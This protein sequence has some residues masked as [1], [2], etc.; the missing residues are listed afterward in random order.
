[1][2][3]WSPSDVPTPLDYFRC[4]VA[5]DTQF[6]LLEAAASLA[7]DPYPQADIESVLAQM[8]AW[9]FRLRRPL[10]AKADPIAKLRRLNQFF[11]DELGFAGNVNDYYAPDNSY[12]HRV[13]DTRRGIP[14]SLSVLWL[15]LAQ[16]LGLQAQGVGFPGHFLV[17]VKLPDPHEGLIV[18]DPFTGQSLGREDLLE[19]IGQWLG[20]DGESLG[21]RKTDLVLSQHL[22]ACSPR[23]MVLRMLKN[24]QEIY[25]SRQEKRLL[26]LLQMRIEILAQSR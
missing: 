4:L 13:M 18:L 3:A 24:L 2:V 20:S 5:S 11:F 17:K 26:H 15:E 7:Q 10:N 25:R 1:M 9:H 6:P 14:I 23:N 21:K 16:G 22:Q 12:L 19:R 8:D